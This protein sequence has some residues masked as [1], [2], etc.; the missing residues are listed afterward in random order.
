MFCLNFSL[1]FFISDASQTNLKRWGLLEFDSDVSAYVAWGEIIKGYKD[2]TA[3]AKALDSAKEQTALCETAA[4][5]GFDAEET[6]IEDY[7]RT[8]RE[9]MGLSDDETGWDSFFTDYKK[10]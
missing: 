5:L 6:E 2:R 7:L 4:A 9:T 8:L 1:F 3:L 10:A